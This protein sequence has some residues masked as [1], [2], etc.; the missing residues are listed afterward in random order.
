[1]VFFIGAAGY[2]LLEILWRGYTH[3]SM[4]FTG[5]I[6]LFI[7]YNVFESI[8]ESHLITKCLIGGLIITTVEL[9]IGM[10]VNVGIGLSVWDYSQMP[11]NL[12]GQICLFYSILWSMLCFPLVFLCRE[13]K[14]F[15]NRYV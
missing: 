15:I 12:Y 14:K 10:I 5:G 11:F 9:I 6:C 4:L 2:G 1:M 13:I 8:K 7:L 3:F